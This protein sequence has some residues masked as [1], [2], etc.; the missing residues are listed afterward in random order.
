MQ[1]DD[2][3]RFDSLHVSTF[4]KHT[5]HDDVLEVKM[6]TIDKLVFSIPSVTSN[7]DSLLEQL[8]LVCSQLPGVDSSLLDTADKLRLL[9]KLLDWEYTIFSKQC[10]GYEIQGEDEGKDEVKNSMR[11]FLDEKKNVLAAMRQRIIQLQMKGA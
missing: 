4:P 7:L 5:N 8:E 11:I 3:A 2:Q 10:Q 9:S 1:A 6:E